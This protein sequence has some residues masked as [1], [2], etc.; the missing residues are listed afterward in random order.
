MARAT[1]FEYS[2]VATWFSIQQVISGPKLVK[3]PVTVTP[4]GLSSMKSF[5]RHKR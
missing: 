1:I 4:A 5:L 2:S 3:Y